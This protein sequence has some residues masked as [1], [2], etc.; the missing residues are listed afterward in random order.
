MTR[1]FAFAAVV[2]LAGMMPFAAQADDLLDRYKAAS[3]MQAEKMSDFMIARVPE[4]EGVIPPT[5]WTAEADV[6]GQCTVDRVRAD[7]GED[8]LEAYV[9][10]VE[11]MAAVEVTSLS[12]MGENIPELLT[13]MYF[14]QVAQD[15]GAMDLAQKQMEESGMLAMMA[16]PGVMERLAAD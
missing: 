13:D 4:L 2:A 7:R 12:Q 8:G 9:A 11:E 3:Q 10:A 15:C 6:V 5:E 1:R 16:D 14:M